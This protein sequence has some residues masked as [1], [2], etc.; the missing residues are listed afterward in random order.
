MKN[1]R[2][3]MKGGAFIKSEGIAGLGFEKGQ[4]YPCPETFDYSNKRKFFKAQK[5][6]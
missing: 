6:L 3:V 4:N 5:L 2:M 1:V